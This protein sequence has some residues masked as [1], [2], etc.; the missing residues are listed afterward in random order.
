MK[1]ALAPLVSY[2]SKLLIL[3]TM[4]GE[5]SIALQQYYGN[6]GNHFWKILFMIFS[7]PF[8]LDYGVRKSLLERHHIALW[9]VLAHCQ[10][11]GSQDNNIRDETA[12]DFV[13]FF[14]KYPNIRHV[15]FESKSAAGFYA[16]H[17]AYKT[18]VCYHT[19]PST[20]G[21]NAGLSFDEKLAQWRLVGIV[22][23]QLTP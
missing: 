19:L 23:E 13:A 8:S 11:K 1:I 2:D 10:R 5:K 12:N 21:L 20:S 17:V 18:G 15:F 9:N 3:G 6:R 14:E 7:E 4:P 16:K 22:S